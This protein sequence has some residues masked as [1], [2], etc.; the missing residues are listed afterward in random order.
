MPKAPARHLVAVWNP[1]YA[2]NAMDEHLRVL[3]D[4]GRRF[5][6]KSVDE[7]DVYVWWGKVKSSNRQQPLANLSD[8]LAVG[9]Q[10]DAAG[11]LHLYLTDYSAL[12]VGELLEVV[13]EQL[14]AGQD[15]HVPAYYDQKELRCDL[16]F[17]L[18]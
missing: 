12:Y 15:A 14:P 11:E 9:E 16:W 17:K 2:D 10:D 1:S 8:A 3:R 6:E 13:G 4:W 7:E 18:G 5:S